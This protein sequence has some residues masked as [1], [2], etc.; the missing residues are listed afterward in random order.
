MTVVH[1]RDYYW[2]PVTSTLDW[3]EENYTHSPYIAEYVNT[4]TN[5]M[6]LSLFGI[7]NTLSNGF[8]KSFIVAH[9]GVIFVGF[10]SWLFH[11]TLKYEMQLLD[12]LPM[13]YVACIMVWHSIEVRPKNQY[14]IALVLGLIGYSAF[15]TYSYLIINNPVFHQVSYAI[16][17]IIVVF[18]SIYLV[19]HLPGGAEQFPYEHPR[20]VVLLKIAASSFLLAFVI[21]NIDNVACPVL[22]HFRTF[23]PYAVGAVSQL[24]GWWHIGTSLGVYYYVVYTQWIHQLLDETNKQKYQL[25]WKGFVCYLKPVKQHK[26]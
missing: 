14:G 4:T 13:I 11:M 15:V 26:E 5:L 18:R 16:L 22:R 17:V 1:P 21:W 6:F 3:C 8:S 2:G 9:F 20:M 25:V 24:H 7:Y 19:R 12:E 23:V 10:G